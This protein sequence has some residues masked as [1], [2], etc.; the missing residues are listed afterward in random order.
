MGYSWLRK[1][2]EFQKN[3]CLYFTDYTKCF[4]CVDHNKLWKLFKWWEY[5]TTLP[6][7]WEICMQVKKQQL[8][9][10]MEQQTGSKSG[11]KYVRSVYYHPAYLVLCRVHH[12]KYQGGWSTS[13]NQDFWEKYQL[14]HICRWHHPYGRKLRRTKEPLNESEREWKSWLQTQH[15]E[16]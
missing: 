3:T 4:D 10:D 5:Q 8:E 9:W 12:V 15:S 2:R 13:W 1:A 11:K 7:S 6:A 14:P 16:N